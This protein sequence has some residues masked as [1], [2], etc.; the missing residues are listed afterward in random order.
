MRVEKRMNFLRV[1]T[2]HRVTELDNNFVLDPHQVSTKPEIFNQQMDFLSR[3]YSVVTI[4]EVLKAIDHE[5]NLPRKAVLITFDDAYS[6]IKDTAWPIL[7]SYGFPV[8]IFVPT[9]FPGAPDRLFWWD[10]LFLSL[11]STAQQ[12]LYVPPVGALNLTNHEDRLASFKKLINYIKTVPYDKA[13]DLVEKVCS[14][15]EVSN[16]GLKSTLNW[17]ELRQ[18]VKEGVTVGA[19]TRTH[20]IL[21]QMPLEKAAE[22]IKGSLGDLK[23]EIGH[24]LPIFCYPNG[25]HTV[26]IK[27]ILRQ[28]GI[29]LAF[30]T[31]DGHNNL[32]QVDPL[33][34]Y[35]TNITRKTSIYIFRLRLWRLFSYM[36][37]WRHHH[38]N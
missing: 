22:E 19:H 14:Q 6:D 24:V 8:T 12:E 16:N 10:R 27:E 31:E 28:E 18:M 4:E 1:L 33:G 21:T 15:M 20:P 13:M 26:H 2:Y 32:S 38:R 35:R 36:D 7:Q 37:R 25:N 17:D 34:L 29:K 11:N 3:Q 23:R 30:G 5:I 9:S